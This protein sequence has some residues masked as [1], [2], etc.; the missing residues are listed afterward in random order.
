MYQNHLLAG[1]WV[2][3]SGLQ[4]HLSTSTNP[5][6]EKT[7]YLRE[8]DDKGRSPS[9]TREST[10]SRSTLSKFQQSFGVLSVALANQALSLLTELFDDLHLEICGA[11]GGVVQVS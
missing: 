2:L 8:R 10:S 7:P 1:A 6:P 4:T 3:V 5:V 11:G 9:K